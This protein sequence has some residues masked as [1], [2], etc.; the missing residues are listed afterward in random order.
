M[1]EEDELKEALRKFMG[2]TITLELILEV[3]AAIR[4]VREKY[5]ALWYSWA[6]SPRPTAKWRVA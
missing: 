1:D 5:D 6:G 2:K 4:P 3:E